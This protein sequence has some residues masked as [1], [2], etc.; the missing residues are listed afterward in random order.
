[1]INR[2]DLSG[3]IFM[4]YTKLIK[5]VRDKLILTQTEFAA[6]L[7]VYYPTVCRWEKGI[8]DPTTKV[9]RKIVELCK[10]NDIKLEEE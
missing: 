5:K 10:E 2:Y 3:G 9:K 4:D 6:L 1:M 7:G 8:H